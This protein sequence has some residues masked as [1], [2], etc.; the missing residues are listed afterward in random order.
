MR[1]E[2]IKTGKAKG[3]PLTK[4]TLEKKIDYLPNISRADGLPPQLISDSKPRKNN[5][6]TISYGREKTLSVGRI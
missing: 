3:L 1:R 5:L 2:T 6:N 4:D